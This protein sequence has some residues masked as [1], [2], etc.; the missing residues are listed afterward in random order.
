[1]TDPCFSL[2]TIASDL[3]FLLL[4]QQQQQ[5]QRADIP[6]QAYATSFS[7]RHAPSFS[8]F[9]FPAVMLDS[10]PMTFDQRDIST[11]K[12]YLRLECAFIMTNADVARHLDDIN[13]TH[14]HMHA[15]G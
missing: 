12:D 15:H 10:R 14:V 11:S 6:A 2:L 1:M 13:S 4:S 7:I 9:F 3:L 5:R 8:R